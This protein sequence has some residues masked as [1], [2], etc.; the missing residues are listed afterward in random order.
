[1]DLQ[2]EKMTLQDFFL[3]SD[4]LHSNFD[5]F[6]TPDTLKQEIEC[7]NSYF[8][9]AKNEG[10][11]VGFAGIKIVFED[12]DLMNI[13]VKKDCRNQQIGSFLLQYLFSYSKNHDI[14][15]IMLEV[16]EKNFSAISLYKKFGFEQ[17]G[18]RKNYY[19]N[20]DNAII[21]KKILK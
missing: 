6:W 4:T 9:V 18:I 15:S 3:I 8:I 10:K 12:A 11:I 1:M 21:M 19:Y 2:I 7:K 13:V 5:T 14:T 17:I 20:K 16:N